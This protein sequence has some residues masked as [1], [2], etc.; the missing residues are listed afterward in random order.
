MIDVVFWWIGCVV[1][2]GAGC[3]VALFL[4]WAICDAIWRDCVKGVDFWFIVDV[5]RR[6]RRRE[7]S[8]KARR[9]SER[10]GGD[11]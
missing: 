1:C 10:K 5:A 6:V 7:K 9:K 3:V 8:R 4:W 2:I 11:A